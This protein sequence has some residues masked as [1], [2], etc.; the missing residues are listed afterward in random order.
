MTCEQVRELEAAFVLGA[1][2]PGEEAA[3]RDHIA[4]CNAHGELASNRAAALVIAYTTEPEE[5]PHGLRDRIL[6]DATASP[7]N[8]TRGR[9]SSS[10]VLAAAA[11]VVVLLGVSAGVVVLTTGS[12]GPHTNTFTTGDGIEVH[13]ETEFEREGAF[14]AFAGLEPPPAGEQYVAW[15]IRNGDWVRIGE[16]RPGEDGAWAGE[17]D[18]AFEEGDALCLTLS[19]TESPADPFG[20]PLFIEPV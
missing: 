13:V 4:D 1:L 14:L 17:F 18:F 5:P 12:D 20:E 2:D 10:R 16:F 11:A 6:A 9:R 15:V 19:G 8:E 3:V 7:A